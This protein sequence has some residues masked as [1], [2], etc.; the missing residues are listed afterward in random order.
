MTDTKL[1]PGIKWG[2]VLSTI[3]IYLALAVAAGIVLIPIFW[4]VSTAFKLYSDTFRIPPMW[5]P[6]YFSLAN[7]QRVFLV[8]P[9][10]AMMFNS[11]KVATLGTLGQVLSCTL[12]GYA[13]ARMRFAGRQPLF[14]VILATMMVPYQVVMIPIFIIM[15][16]IGWVNSH[17]A[18]IVPAFLGGAFGIFLMRQFFL[19]LPNELE[20]AA[21]IDGANPFQ[22]FTKIVLPLAKPALTA[23]AALSFTAFWNDLLTPLIYLS[24]MDRM[25]MPVG[26]SFFKGMHTTE[27]NLLMAAA[28]LNIIPAAII[29]LLTQRQLV[30][31]IA[32]SGG[33]KG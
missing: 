2:K 20:D 1:R 8:V 19:T 14:M 13:I 10:G 31:G 23:L 27:W 21:R 7:F 26:I 24:T 3:G 30:S 32:L 17:A 18:L 12:A 5:F 28:L 22:I 16:K 6:P 29:F 4:M 9:F 25:T 15:T 11:L 33:I